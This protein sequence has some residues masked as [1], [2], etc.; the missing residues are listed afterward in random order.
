MSNDPVGQV[1]ITGFGAV[2]PVGLDR[3][4]TW[5][6][7]VAGKSATGPIT[8]FDPGDLPVRIA[9]E[10]HGFAP[11][12]LLDRRRL[13]RTARFSQ[14]ALAAAR[15]AVADARLAIGQSNAD[16]IGVVVNAAVAGF[17]TVEAATRL[18]I[19]GDSRLS[20]Y[21]VSSSL[22]NMPALVPPGRHFPRRPERGVLRRRR[23]RPHARLRPGRLPG[24]GR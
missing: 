5:Q 7:L 17:D 8:A 23:R 11:A 13:R 3:E 22:A 2:T 19:G 24:Y 1:A 16:R 20:P 14:L 12:Q 4:S 6:N 15:E 21:F 18:L 9:A 10:V